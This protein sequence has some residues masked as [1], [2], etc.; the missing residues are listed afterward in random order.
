MPCVGSPICT[1]QDSPGINP[2]PRHPMRRHP[3]AAPTPCSVTPTLRSHRHEI[4]RISLGD[5]HVLALS[6]VGLVLSWGRNDVGQLGTGSAQPPSLLS[7]PPSLL[8]SPP[9]ATPLPCHGAY[10]PDS[11]P[12]AARRPLPAALPVFGSDEVSMAAPSV[13][14][15]LTVARFVEVAS[16]A[17]CS[18]A[19]DADG[20]L[21]W[22]PWDPTP[23]HGHELC[24][25]F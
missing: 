8:S 21:W 12:D 4:H 11:R 10:R 25:P 24:P 6:A 1:P 5:E 17:R 15:A 14:R 18:G 20:R 13:V 9:P 16:G 7:Y 3:S 2:F 19:I 22:V 23:A